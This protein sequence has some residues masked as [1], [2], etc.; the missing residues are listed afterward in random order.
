MNT[1][2]IRNFS[3]LTVGTNAL[4]A[5][6]V[7]E[8]SSTEAGLLIPRMTSTQRLAITSPATGLFVFDTTTLLFYYWDGVAW[9]SLS[10]G[11]PGDFW[12]IRDTTSNTFVRAAPDGVTS[13]NTIT[14]QLGNLGANFTA[15]QTIFQANTSGISID[16]IS[17]APETAQNGQGIFLTSGGGIPYGGNISLYSDVGGDGSTASGNISL[18]TA[19]CP[20]NPIPGN[21]GIIS[22]ITGDLN[23][24]DFTGGDDPPFGLSRFY[25]RDAGAYQLVWNGVDAWV[26]DIYNSGGQI[27]TPPGSVPDT[28]VFTNYGTD[29][30]SD[31]PWDGTGCMTFSGTSICEDK[32]PPV[33]TAAAPGIFLTTG[34]SSGVYGGGGKIV[35]QTGIGSNEEQT[36]NFFSGGVEVR[37]GDA[38]ASFSGGNGAGAGDISL[39]PGSGATGDGNYP[40]GNSFVYGGRGPNPG[41]ATLMGGFPFDN[42]IGGHAYV[43]GGTSPVDST[44]DPGNAYVWGGDT[45]SLES[46]PNQAGHVY[47]RGGQAVDS[48]TEPNTGGDVWIGGG[49]GNTIGRVIVGQQG[50]STIYSLLFQSNNSNLCGFKAPSSGIN[51][52][53]ELPTN[54]GTGGQVLT[55]STGDST[56][57]ANSSFT[58]TF[59]NGSLVAGILTVNH[60]LN[61][62][63]VLIQIYDQNGL[64][65]VPDQVQLMDNNTLDVNMASFGTISGTWSLIIK[66]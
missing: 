55:R 41:N 59:T 29:Y 66:N 8:M 62:S 19:T 60:N 16:S 48:S 25:C 10:A 28:W 61:F 27:L 13:S 64:M 49:R 5:S 32:C 40:A 4:D 33:V 15:N 7:V 11:T 24:V 47:I 53:W 43:R 39:I 50:D 30:N 31:S 46:P 51:Q 35:L 9:V 37:T 14:A 36:G 63:P 23:I 45:N 58:M 12:I 44:L 18:E 56:I 20:Q 3:N 21:K 26:T 1:G 54:A 38:A 34:D 22:L 6:A 42:G 17:A 52:T 2:K 57:W 65:A